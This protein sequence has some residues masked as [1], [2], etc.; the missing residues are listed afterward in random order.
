MIVRG[1]PPTMFFYA[2]DIV[3]GPFYNCSTCYM[4]YLLSRQFYLPEI[5]DIK[6][7]NY[8]S[9]GIKIADLPE[10]RNSMVL[11]MLPRDY[12]SNEWVRLVTLDMKTK[13]KN[14][15]SFNIHKSL[16]TGLS[17]LTFRSECCCNQ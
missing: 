16:D 6:I 12:W 7:V 15:K 9:N 14:I 2:G 13:D 11:K 10:D 8:K 4:T 5:G 1:R 3:A 17:R